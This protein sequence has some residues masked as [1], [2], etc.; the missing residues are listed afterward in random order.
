MCSNFPK[1]TRELNLLTTE[2]AKD[3]TNFIRLC[4]EVPGSMT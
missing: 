4:H 2:T 3:F 1:R